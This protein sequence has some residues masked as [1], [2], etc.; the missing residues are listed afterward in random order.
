MTTPHFA[1]DCVCHQE[2]C[3][4]KCHP[5]TH[6]LKWG[7]VLCV[8]W[9]VAA[10][11]CGHQLVRQKGTTRAAHVPRVILLGAILVWS[12]VHI[13]VRC[14]FT[15]HMS[16]SSVCARQEVSRWRKWW[17]SWS[18][19]AQ[20]AD[21]KKK[22]KRIGKTPAR[23]LEV[24]TVLYTLGQT[25]GEIANMCTFGTSCAREQPEKSPNG[26]C[27]ASYCSL[28]AVLC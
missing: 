18:R 28:L 27:V 22:Q 17:W 6:N 23:V 12:L 15:G 25:P 4:S 3:V 16:L 19:G 2:K 10:C 14:S 8:R 21:G 13:T 20:G 9:T 5:S 24:V 1:K 26:K 7:C 11:A